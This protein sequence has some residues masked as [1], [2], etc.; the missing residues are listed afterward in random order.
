[1]E[2]NNLVAP[3]KTKQNLL[4]V[5]ELLS[6]SWQIY[7]KKFSD[8]VEM[9]LW[10]LLGLLPLIGVGFLA[11]IL[12]LWLDLN[13]WPV[14]IF[15]SI[16]GLAALAWSIYYG[17]RAKIGLLLI[18]QNEAASVKE[19]FNQSREYFWPYFI[20]S[21]VT[22]LLILLAML[23][24]I[25]PGLVLAIY[26]SFVLLVTVIEKKK[27]VGE[28]TKRSYEL[29]K[30]YWWPVCGRIILMVVLALIVSAILN[31][32]VSS[33]D[34]T[35]EKAYTVVINIFW[36][37]VSPLFLVYSYLLYQDLVKKN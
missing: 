19:K 13:L 37:L 10:G 5:G 7:I 22:T 31:I 30:G 3:V 12:F 17:T 23:L 4:S 21:I 32:P 2:D 14:Y 35:A 27:T 11:A 34:G 6:S 29:V 33:L 16:L 9:Y 26:W 15:V 8:F 18:I 25:I 20:V 28:A 24:L 36:A 1:M